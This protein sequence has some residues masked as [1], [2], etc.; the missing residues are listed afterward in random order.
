MISTKGVQ[1]IEQNN[2]TPKYIKVGITEVLVAAVKGGSTPNGTPFIEISTENAEGAT[3]NS[4][5][6]FKEG[7]NAQISTAA[8]AQIAEATGTRELVDA[9]VAKDY[10]DYGNKL[11]TILVGKKFRAKFNGTEKLKRDGS[12]TWI[13]VKLGS[14]IFAESLS[15]P[16]TG[17]ILQWSEEKNVKRLP[18]G[19][20][21]A[22]SA[23]AQP[24][25]NNDLPF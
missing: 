23:P 25:V 17:S 20:A 21:S 16:S 18:Q 4:S 5:F 12:G 22:A 10:E 8:L 1:A 11:N 15:V 6:Y 19:A 9:I 2:N 3:N 13:E 14:G 24:V 7:L